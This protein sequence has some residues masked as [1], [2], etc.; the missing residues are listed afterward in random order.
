MDIKEEIINRFGSLKRFSKILNVPIGTVYSWT[1]KKHRNKPAK[2][3]AQAYFDAAE[4]R[5]KRVEG[6]LCKKC[7]NVSIDNGYAIKPPHCISCGSKYFSPLS[8]IHKTE[9][10]ES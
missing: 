8:I 4:Y 2:W 7:G 3:I 5:S 10:K 1:R 9:A 6:W